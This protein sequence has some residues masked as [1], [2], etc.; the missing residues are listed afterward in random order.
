[1]QVEVESVRHP[2]T[3]SNAEAAA[4]CALKVDCL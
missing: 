1:M 2:E 4:F 3:D